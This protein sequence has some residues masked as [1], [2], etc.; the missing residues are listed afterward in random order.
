[1][2]DNSLFE[3]FSLSLPSLA[4][5][6]LLFEERLRVPKTLLNVVV[7]VFFSSGSSSILA[8]TV[9][10]GVSSKL[11]TAFGLGIND[12]SDDFSLFTKS[13]APFSC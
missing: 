7:D 13:K 3:P 10:S 8:A 11:V 5:V 6:S 2:L 9:G 12:L 4:N 1:M